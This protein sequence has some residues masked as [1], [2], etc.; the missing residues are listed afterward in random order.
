MDVREIARKLATG[1][2]GILAADESSRTITKRFSGVNKEST[3]ATRSDYRGT[4]FTT[5]GIEQFISGVILYDETA[6]LKVDD[7]CCGGKTVIEHL[8]S[9]DIVPGI[10]VDK[11]TKPLAKNARNRNAPK[12][13]QI[14]EGLDGLRERCA[15]YYEMGLRFT[16][17]RGVIDGLSGIEKPERYSIVANA[18]ALARFAAICQ[19]EGLCPI[20]EPE[21]LLDN[22]AHIESVQETTELVLRIVFDQLYENNVDIRGIILKPN[23]VMPGYHLRIKC[24]PDKVAQDTLDVLSKTVPP[25]VPGIAFLSGGQEEIEA[26]TNLAAINMKGIYPWTLIFSFGRALQKSAMQLWAEGN[27]T[28]AQKVFLYRAKMNCRAITRC[29]T[30]ESNVV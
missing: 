27:R 23:M 30:S 8:T 11:G 15:E 22:A 17:W 25:A 29:Y 21:V 7:A 3:L 13:Y 6:R 26:T 9:L 2:K 20:V 16:K 19:D 24:S 5:E 28:E 4:L 14:T 1:T 18:H 12:S 10:K